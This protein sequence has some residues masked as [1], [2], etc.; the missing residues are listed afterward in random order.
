M[1]CFPGQRLPSLHTHHSCLTNPYC[2]VGLGMA[3]ISVYNEGNAAL[4]LAMMGL[5][6]ALW[7]EGRDSQCL[8]SKTHEPVLLA[9]S[10]AQ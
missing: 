2:R 3:A 8:A 9:V 1:A 6:R 10:L 5:Q 7:Q 4:G